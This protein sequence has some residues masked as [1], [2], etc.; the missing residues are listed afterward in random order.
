MRCM[1]KWLLIENSQIR[2]QKKNWRKK[3]KKNKNQKMLWSTNWQPWRMRRW[4]SFGYSWKTDFTD[5][6]GFSGFLRGWLNKTILQHILTSHHL[7]MITQLNVYCFNFKTW[8]SKKN[9]KNFHQFSNQ[10]K[11]RIQQ[12]S[13]RWQPSRESRVYTMKQKTMFN[14][15]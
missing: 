15:G 8:K 2:K 10:Q 3:F 7:W 9:R 14:S 13:K 5:K 12:A 11:F 1:K 6:M 4:F